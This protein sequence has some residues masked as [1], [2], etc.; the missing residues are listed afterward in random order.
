V[1]TTVIAWAVKELRID[2]LSWY[3]NGTLCSTTRKPTIATSM[4]PEYSIFGIY[5]EFYGS[6]FWWPIGLAERTEAGT[7]PY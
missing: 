5:L 3:M 1:T 6:R 7:P 2:I 4:P